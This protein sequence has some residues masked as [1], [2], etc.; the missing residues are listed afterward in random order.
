MT[1]DALL[2]EL[3]ARPELRRL[4]QLAHRRLEQTGGLPSRAFATMPAPTA[5]ERLAVDRLL[6][7]RSRGAAVRV[8]LDRL[9]TVLR[10]RAATS[11]VDVVQ[12]A[13]GPLRDLPAERARQIELDQRFWE[14]AAEHRAV[15]RHPDLAPWFAQVRAT[16]RL[17]RLDDPFRR[18]QQTLD[19][20]AELPTSPPTGRSSLAAVVL[21]ESHALD[22]GQP[23]GRL[24]VAALAHLSG[25]DEPRVLDAAGR[26]SLW[27]EFGVRTDETSSTVLTLG[28]RPHPAG[29][30]T[31]AAGQ[32]ATAG[33]PLPIP[34]AALATESWTVPARTVVSVC[35]NPA[36]VEAAALRFS[37]ASPPL[38]CVEGMPSLA[39]RRLLT[40]L[41]DGGAS[42]RYHGDFGSGGVAIANVVIGQLGAEPWRFDT[43]SHAAA[44]A[45]VGAAGV[46]CPPLRGP[47]PPAG[48]DDGLA[49]AIE[50]AGVEIEE[51]QVLAVLLDDLAALES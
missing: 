34:L 24:V 32:W 28:L 22:D 7:T 21:G 25:E 4:W 16:G 45:T 50:R 20:L 26:R 46:A 49:S 51:E 27:L 17:R 2:T 37:A 44:L 13:C 9:D 48:W 19:V 47:V 6:G 39:A 1:S 38:V 8:A 41:R 12:A 40:S 23:T 42:L 14:A 18:L 31:E 33:V 5:D 35:E 3:A 43:T 10:Q 29:P 15:A 36:L 11:L 30:L